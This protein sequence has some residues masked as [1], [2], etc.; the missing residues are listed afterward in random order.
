M[1]LGPLGRSRGRGERIEK[2][3]VGIQNQS[4]SLGR[5]ENYVYMVSRI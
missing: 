4:L 3:Q 1:R 5:T 2:V